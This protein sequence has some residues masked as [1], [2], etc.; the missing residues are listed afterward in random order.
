[1]IKM[2]EEEKANF[3]EAVQLAFK[4]LIHTMDELEIPNH[5][6]SK[7]IVGE[8]EYHL[9]IIKSKSSDLIKGKG[10]LNTLEK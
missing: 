9:T 10:E 8:H 4:V 5:I 7:A 2:N 6:I 1:M 3:E